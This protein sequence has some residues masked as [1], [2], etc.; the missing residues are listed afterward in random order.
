MNREEVLAAVEGVQINVRKAVE[1]LN[2]RINELE[3]QAELSIKSASNLS[4]NMNALLFA[5]SEYGVEVR[6]S[7]TPSGEWR[8][9]EIIIHN[10]K[11][12]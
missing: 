9:I 2:A 11:E 7:A 4:N 8:D 1:P 10:K 12:Q 3:L 5:L 6:P